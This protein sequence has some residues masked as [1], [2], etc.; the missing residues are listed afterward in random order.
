MIQLCIW[1]AIALLLDTILIQLRSLC[2]QSPDGLTNLDADSNS[3]SQIWR[4]AS[5][6]PLP[7]VRPII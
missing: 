6:A 2:R 4:C 1:N 3:Q 7:L 5:S